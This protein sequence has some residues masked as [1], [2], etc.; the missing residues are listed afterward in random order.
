MTTGSAIIAML[1]HDAPPYVYNS[2]A[3]PLPHSAAQLT[4]L[5]LFWGVHVSRISIQSHESCLRAVG[6]VQVTCELPMEG[7]A[8]DDDTSG[9]SPI[10]VAV[11]GVLSNTFW[12]PTSVYSSGRTS[13]EDP[14]PHKAHL[15]TPP[16]LTH[17]QNLAPQQSH[18]VAILAVI[19]GSQYKPAALKRAY[20][21]EAPRQRAACPPALHPPA[22]PRPSCAACSTSQPCPA[23]P[24]G[25]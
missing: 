7:A 18:V 25:L 8:G 6:A 5:T 22:P 9:A 10:T 24:N 12:S 14:P 21:A 4:R 11:N 2:P 15:C 23:C 1:D 19:Q 17:A 20:E 16:S 13:G 3:S